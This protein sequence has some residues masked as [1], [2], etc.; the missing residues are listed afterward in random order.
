[1]RRRQYQ[2]WVDRAGERKKEN[3]QILAM[4]AAQDPTK[5]AKTRADME[6]ADK[7]AGE[8]LKKLADEEPDNAGQL[9]VYGDKLRAQIA[10]M[11]PQ[12][13]SAPAWIVGN[14]FVAPNTPNANAITRINP[15]FYRARKSPA[16]VRAILVLMPNRNPEYVAEQH[17][18]MYRQFD[19]AALKRL[20]A[21]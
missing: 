12:E 14:D 11:T 6:K 21:Y 8:F 9:T 4:L 7:E 16:E 10:A 5:V 18:Q 17:L 1:V 19:W 3:E 2:E 13:R 20:L 15:A